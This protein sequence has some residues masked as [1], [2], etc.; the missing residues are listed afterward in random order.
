MEQPPEMNLE[1]YKKYFFSSKY[2]KS[3][4][5]FSRFMDLIGVRQWKFT[6]DNLEGDW[7][8]RWRLNPYNPLTYIVLLSTIIIMASETVWKALTI[9]LIDLIKSMFEWN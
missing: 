9:D 8:Y 6:D 7:V 4:S 5:K 3:L 1:E 2:Y